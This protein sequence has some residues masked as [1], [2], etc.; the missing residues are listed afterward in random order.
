MPK[1]EFPVKNEG[2]K[3]VSIVS[4]P[5]IQDIEYKL[6]LVLEVCSAEDNYIEYNL[7]TK[8]YSN[9]EVD[10]RNFPRMSFDLNNFLYRVFIDMMSDNVLELME[11]EE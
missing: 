1:I 7:I 3:K 9:K 10:I 8:A 5:T 11:K 4:T 2:P 6:K